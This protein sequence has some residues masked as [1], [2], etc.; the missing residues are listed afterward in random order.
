MVSASF[1][2]LICHYFY[3][4]VVNNCRF[5]TTVDHICDLFLKINIQSGESI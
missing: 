3:K 2:V 5:F 4:L 1:K